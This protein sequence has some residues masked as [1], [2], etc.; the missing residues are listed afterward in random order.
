MWSVPGSELVGVVCARSELRSG[1]PPNSRVCG[2]EC[3]EPVLTATILP[4]P[5]LN[6]YCYTAAAVQTD[7]WRKFI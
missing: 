5:E 7:E 2:L 4:L 6:E 3:T 1:Q